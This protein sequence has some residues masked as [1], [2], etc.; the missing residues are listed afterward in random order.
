MNEIVN[1]KPADHFPLV[2]KPGKKNA[3]LK[4]KAGNY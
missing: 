4:N 3:S 1:K 2:S